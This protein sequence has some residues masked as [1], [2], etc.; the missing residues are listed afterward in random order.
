M[1]DQLKTLSASYKENGKRTG[2]YT[3]CLVTAYLFTS[4]GNVITSD[5]HDIERIKTMRDSNHPDDI[6]SYRYPRLREDK[7]KCFRSQLE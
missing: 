3:K 5:T 4:D 1:T 6:V 2:T 7:W